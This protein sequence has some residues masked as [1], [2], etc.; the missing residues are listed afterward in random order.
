[1]IFAW[2]K[3]MESARNKKNFQVLEAQIQN[4]EIKIIFMEHWS[5]KIILYLHHQDKCCNN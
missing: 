4:T 5:V 3:V 1:M 2:E